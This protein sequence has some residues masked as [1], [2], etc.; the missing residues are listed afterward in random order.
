MAWRLKL[1]NN[2]YNVIIVGS[3]FAGIVSAD[4]LSGHGL[5]VLLVDENFHSGGQL[6]RKISDELGDSK[7]HR[8]TYIKRLGNR[9]LDKLKKNRIEIL[10]R[11]VVLG[12]YDK[13]EM[14]IEVDNKKVEKFYYDNLIFATGA[15]ERF[16]PFKGWTLP[17]VISTGMSQVLMKSYGVLPSKRVL[18]AG[19]GLFLFSV[20]Y[21]LLKNGAKVISVLE[22]TPF[23]NKV[24]LLPSLI[25]AP[26]KAAEGILY[27]SKIVSSGVSI[28]YNT[29][30]LEARGSNVLEEVVIAKTDRN[31]NI[32]NGSEKIIKTDSL[33]IGF[34]FSPNVELPSLAGCK[35]EFN[36]SLGGWIVKVDDEMK[37]S[38]DGIFSAG[39]ITGVGGALKSINEGKIAAFSI[40]REM[41][42][43][44]EK[45]F[46]KQNGKLLKER[47]NNLIFS[48]YFNTLYGIRAKDLDIISDDTVICR[49]E[50]V[51]MGEIRSA[52][53]EGFVTPGALK[54]SVRAGMGNCQG[55]TCG[56]LIY[57]LLDLSSQDHPKEP[58]S[59][60]P[61]VKPVRVKKLVQE[62]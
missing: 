25:H 28:K 41:Q 42:K 37:T 22:S 30:V 27:M 26:S 48:K 61:P 57:D 45:D 3:G 51:S 20:T 18:V 52:V 59:T 17:G 58:F 24:K 19:S 32:K 53:K 4:I 33:A 38:V 6:L 40:L 62:R 23:M 50:D 36:R 54:L 55:R 13:N 21:E 7:K 49:C 35:L 47:K 1:K 46:N 60:R 12:I 31:G 39:E 14:L 15:R 56:P 8:N 5:S 29:R 9:F 10:K 11:S 34:G 2:R 43:I 16:L 44:S